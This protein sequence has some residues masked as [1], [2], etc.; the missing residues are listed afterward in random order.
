MIRMITSSCYCKLYVVFQSRGRPESCD[1]KS[2]TDEQVQDDFKTRILFMESDLMR[3][4]SMTTTPKKKIY[5]KEDVKDEHCN[6][7]WF[8]PYEMSPIVVILIQ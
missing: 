3:S 4:L 1:Q 8:K 6:P 7:L 2:F 5:D